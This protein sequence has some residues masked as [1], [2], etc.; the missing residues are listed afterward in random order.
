MR[1]VR[2]GVFGVLGVLASALWAGPHAARAGGA[3]AAAADFVAKTAYEAV[4]SLKDP[5]AGRAER[6]RRL[7][8]FLEERFAGG[9]IAKWALGRHWKKASEA[10]RRRYLGV[11]SRL[12][13]QSWAG[14]LG[15]Y[16]GENLTVIKSARHDEKDVIVTTELRRPSGGGMLKIGWRVRGSDGDLRVLDLMIE[17]V[18]MA[19][20]QR[21]EFSSALRRAGGDMDVFLDG[22]ESRLATMTAAAGESG[23]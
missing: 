9:K 5:E 3:E 15:D 11:Y 2:A 20:L 4:R 22:L 17:G 12:M 18:S 23:N 16:G 8:V 1:T 14:R 13:V 19:A 6:A 7:S 21:A 10:Q